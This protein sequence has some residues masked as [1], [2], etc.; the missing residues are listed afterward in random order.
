MIKLRTIGLVVA[1]AALAV[2]CA[3]IPSE[4]SAITAAFHGGPSESPGGTYFQQGQV[5]NFCFTP[6]HE[7]EGWIELNSQALGNCPPGH[8]QLSVVADPSGWPVPSP[9]PTGG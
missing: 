3:F 7:S 9:T 2:E 4:A 8:V 6:G 1:A 5:V